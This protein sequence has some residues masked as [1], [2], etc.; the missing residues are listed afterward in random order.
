MPLLSVPNLEPS[1]Y[2]GAQ[3]PTEGPQHARCR[4]E[5]RCQS[6]EDHPKERKE[7]ACLTGLLDAPA[8]DL[9]RG[10]KA[11]DRRQTERAS[12]S[13]GSSVPAWE[14][15]RTPRTP[16]GRLRCSRSG[17]DRSAH[18]APIG[19]TRLNV[20]PNLDLPRVPLRGARGSVRSDAVSRR[21]RDEARARRALYRLRDPPCRPEHPRRLAAERPAAADHPLRGRPDRQSRA[22]IPRGTGRWCSPASRP[23]CSGLA[24]PRA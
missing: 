8:E 5:E 19:L 23:T 4:P 24:T 2:A 15:A 16:G 13:P 11:G 9:R 3:Q 21:T 12:R 10:P 20:E 17:R 18:R 6:G 1:A 14:I 7:R 22:S